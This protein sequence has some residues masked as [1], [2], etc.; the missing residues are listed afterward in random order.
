MANPLLA[1][2]CPFAQA[3]VERLGGRGS[4]PTGVGGTSARRD[5]RVCEC[6][7]PERQGFVRQPLEMLKL[8][9]Y[10]ILP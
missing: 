4:L 6:D 1:G 2:R 7:E 5:P 8:R 3:G 10:M 9:H